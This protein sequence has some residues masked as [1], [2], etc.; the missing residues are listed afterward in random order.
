MVPGGAEAR[1]VERQG[2]RKSNTP[3]RADGT[4]A[5][6]HEAVGGLPRGLVRRSGLAH[7][8]LREQAGTPVFARARL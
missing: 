6:G 5:I 7:E 1:K 4:T 8:V 2:V 3:G